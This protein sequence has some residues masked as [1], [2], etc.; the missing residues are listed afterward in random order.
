[1]FLQETSLH[2][3]HM[4]RTCRLAVATETATHFFCRL[5]WESIYDDVQSKG[6]WFW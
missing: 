6:I 5:G 3:G 2:Q 4:W 1:M